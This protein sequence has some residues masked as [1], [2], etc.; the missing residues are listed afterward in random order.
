MRRERVKLLLVAD[1]PGHTTGYR[2]VARG[3]REGGIEVVLG[4]HQIPDR[5]AEMAVQEDVDWV[6]YRIMDGAP[7]ILV[8]RLMEALQR[9]GAASIGVV[10]G[11]IV[12][13]PTVPLLTALGVRAV[14]PP[15]SSL[16]QIVRTL[17]SRPEPPAARGV[18]PETPAS[19]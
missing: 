1:T 13:P 9:R 11:G 19:P 12:P 14:F 5:I 18:S 6:G 7:E 15:G 4:G 8:P 16:P 2:I 3:L 10:V 17:Q